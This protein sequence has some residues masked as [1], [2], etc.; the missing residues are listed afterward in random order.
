M[1]YRV[2]GITE[3]SLLFLESALENY[4]R[5]LK[6]WYERIFLGETFGASHVT[7][8]DFQKFC[9]Q[10]T[11]SFISRVKSVT[12]QFHAFTIFR[13]S[14]NMGGK[15]STH[16]VLSTFVCQFMIMRYYEFEKFEI[17]HNQII[18]NLM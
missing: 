10:V 15:S 6:S 11:D 8:D 7:P 5:C 18:T 1:I 17:C 13:P 3:R 14:L 2:L 16:G 9:Q 4:Q 12:Q